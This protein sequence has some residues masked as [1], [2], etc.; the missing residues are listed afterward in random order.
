MKIP[1]SKISQ[2]EFKFCINENGVK[3]EGYLKRIKPTL[4]ECKA[5][6]KAQ[7]SCLCSRCGAEMSEF[8][9]SELD[10]ILS[11]GCY[12]NSGK[13]EDVIEFFGLE[14]DLGEIIQSEIE[15]FKSDYFYCKN[16]KNLTKE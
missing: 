15:S 16:C 10:L 7:I 3:F 5:N 14:V 8:M 1:F 4:V 6:L 2:N 13:L 9:D 11:Q 12:E